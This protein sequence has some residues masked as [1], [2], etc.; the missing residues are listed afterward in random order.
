MDSARDFDLLGESVA[1]VRVS[2]RTV[3][4]LGFFQFILT[5]FFP[6]HISLFFEHLGGKCSQAF[7]C[8]SFGSGEKCQS[9]P[10]RETR[11]EYV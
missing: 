3:A 6:N 4:L 9:A 8:L 11:Q 2:A 10:W 5:P 7:D 1:Q